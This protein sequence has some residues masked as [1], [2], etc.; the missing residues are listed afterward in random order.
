MPA[1]RNILGVSAF[2]HDAAAL[3]NRPILGDARSTKMSSVMNLKVKFRERV[4]D[5]SDLRRNRRR[6]C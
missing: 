6:C 3:G 5:Y 4:A 2:Y 1:T